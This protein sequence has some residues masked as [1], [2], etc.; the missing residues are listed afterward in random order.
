MLSDQA[1]II[2]QMLYTPIFIK[3][4]CNVIKPSFDYKTNVIHTACEKNT[5]AMLSNQFV[6]RIQMLY[7]LPVEKIQMQCYQTE[8]CIEYKPIK[9][10]WNTIKPNGVWFSF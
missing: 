6:N 7:T 3:Y 9:Y 2:I 8:Y 4:K 10:K 5:I 1:V